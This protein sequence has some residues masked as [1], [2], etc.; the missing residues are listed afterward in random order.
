MGLTWRDVVHTVGGLGVPMEDVVLAGSVPLLAHGVLS[1]VGDIDLVARGAAWQS[2][3]ARGDVR[4]GDLGDHYVDLPGG[5]QAFSG[6]RGEP[7][8]A[9]LARSA[10]IDGIHVAS[11]ADVVAYKRRLGRPKDLE[12]LAAIKR[13]A[14]EMSDP[15]VTARREHT[16]LAD[17]TAAGERLA[18]VLAALAPARPA[19]LTLPRGGVPVAAPIARALGCSLDVLVVRKLGLPSNPEYAFGAIGEGGEP[20][21]DERIVAAADLLDSEVAAVVA[22]ERRE[23]TRRVALYRGDGPALSLYGRTAIVV[24]DGAA[25]GSTAQA[26]VAVARALGAADVIVA[27]GTAPPDVLAMLGRHAD[28]AVAAM[29]PEP[30]LS[31]GQW[32]RDFAQVD[33]DEVLAIL[34]DGN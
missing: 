2:L 28:R 5:V 30:F 13:W 31:V 24:D 17:R 15:V 33:D 6:W 26:S 29:T 32:Y 14:D 8:D 7:A 18:P 27:V 16:V 21:I 22:A 20:L 19:V 11:L 12:H 34:R 1:E 10:R 4:A 9:V 23:L 3:S 25:T